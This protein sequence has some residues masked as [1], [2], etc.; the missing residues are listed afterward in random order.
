VKRHGGEQIGAT[1]TEW[2]NK[3]RVG[4]QGPF[5]RAAAMCGHEELQP[6][7]NARVNTDR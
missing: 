4:W 2:G 3:G 6:A 5:Y 1:S 7:L